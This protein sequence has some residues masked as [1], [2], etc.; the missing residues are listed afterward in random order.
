MSLR[1]SRPLVILLADIELEYEM[2]RSRAGC[3]KKE[4]S[5]E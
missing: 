4:I 2:V 1:L 3:K 5:D